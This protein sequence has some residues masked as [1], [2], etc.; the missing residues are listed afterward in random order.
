MGFDDVFVHSSVA[1]PQEVVFLPPSR[2]V[3]NRLVKR[4]LLRCTSGSFL[5]VAVLTGA[6]HYWLVTCRTDF[7]VWDV[8]T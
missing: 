4:A 6:V 5:S 2:S 1:Q 7:M 8:P 3:Y